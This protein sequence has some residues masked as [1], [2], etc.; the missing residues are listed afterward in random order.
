MILLMLMLSFST[1]QVV[2]QAPE[3]GPRTDFLHIKN[4]GVEWKEFAALETGEIDIVD[5]RLTKTFIDRFA[6]DPEIV[7]ASFGDIG[8]YEYDIY[9]QK[10]PTG[11]GE[12]AEYDPETDTYKHWFD[13][14]NEWDVR[15]WGFRLALAYLTDK[16]YIRTEILKGYG[17]ML[18]TW[19]TYPQLGWADLDNLTD[20]S[21]IY[22]GAD[23]IIGTAD[24]VDIPSLIYTRNVAKAQELL[25]SAGFTVNTATNW[26]I[27]PKGDWSTTG[28]AGGDLKPLIFYIRLDDTQRKQSGEKLAADMKAIGIPVDVRVTEKTVCYKAVM[29]EYNYHLY[30]GGYSY[31][32]DPWE[33]L[34]G[35][36]H[37]EQ[38]WA[39]I[40]WAGGYQGFCHHDFDHYAGDMVKNGRT[41]EEIVEGVHGATY[42]ANKYVCSIPLWSSAGVHAYRADWEGVVNHEGYGI[43]WGT[44]G[45]YL[46]SLFNMYK[47]G[48]DTINFGFKSN[49]EEL[50][51]VT[52]EWV[53]CNIVT[54]GIYDTLVARNPY[55]L[56]E[57]R[58]ILA[59]S[60][61]TGTWDTD[62]IYVNFTLRDDVKWHD[63][64]LFTPEDA[65]WGIEFVRDCGPGVAWQG[66]QNLPN[67]DHVDT[68]S[69]GIVVYFETGSYWA[70]NLA[71]M[72]KA[73]PSRKI[74]M[75][76]SEAIG[77]GYDPET[78]TF[79]DRLAVREYRPWEMDVYDASTGGVGSDGII[80]LVQDGTGA[81][82]FVGADRLL[83]EYVDLKANR[84]YFLSQEEV[85]TYLEDAFW[86][87]GDTN[88]DREVDIGDMQVL[89]RALGTDDTWTP[90]DDWNQYNVDADLNSDG[91][92]DATDLGMAGRSYGKSAG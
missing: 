37:S 68:W 23:L 40:G 58:G 76:A 49:I 51:V 5:W 27:D 80:D 57:A 31:G 20:S 54:D 29:Q 14:T 3:Y 50:N 88:R 79:E 17:N 1:V 9:N 91:E 78:H 73:F 32:A 89:A 15:A 90:G 63:G 48:T 44:G 28:A 85:S 87:V 12:P 21:F 45:V 83:Y 16:D 60:W 34:H 30:T 82:I 74:W 46:W 43:P 77:F 11:V 7:L 35:D 61:T 19:L 47:P 69:N 52:A 25:D 65:K 72:I 13:P 18:P 4:Y 75:A 55:N 33:I 42:I 22:P 53:W 71:G 41:Y 24:D 64:T 2:S 66:M 26:R 56:A 6:V 10:W 81:W 38:Y 59:T 70:V 92:I 67:V 39:P 8:S 36:F 84:E 86:S 62:K